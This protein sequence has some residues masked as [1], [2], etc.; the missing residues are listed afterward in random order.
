AEENELW[1][2]AIE[3]YSR[4]A[5]QYPGDSRFPWAL[6]SL[7]YSRR[8]YNLAWEQYRRVEA[9]GPQDTDILYRLSQTAGHLNWDWVSTEYLERIL[10]IDPGN[11]ESIGSLG[12]MYYK[13]HRPEEG[14]RLLLDAMDR[15]GADADYAMTLGTIYSDMFR[16]EEAKSWYLAAI[17]GGEE[18]G[19]REFTAVAHYNLSILE[20]RFYRFGLA[21]ERTNASLN[22]RNRASG[23]LARGELFLRRLDLPQTFAE[24][25]A[26]YEIDTSPLS[27][28]NLA[29]AYQI[30]GRLEEARL[31]AEDCLNSKDLSWMINYGIDPD[32]YKRDLHEILYITYEGLVKTQGRT[33]YASLGD[34]VRGFFRGWSYR[35][36]AASHR[37]LY[38]KYCLI[39]AGAYQ[40]ADPSAGER[41]DAL[42]R[43][44]NA[45][46]SYPR[47]ALTYLQKARQFEIPIIPQAES[48]YDAEEGILLKNTEQLAAAIPR[49][50]PLWER[51]VIAG[52]YAELAPQLAGKNRTAEA[53]DA[54]ERLYALNRGGLRQNGLTLPVELIINPGDGKDNPSRTERVLRRTLKKMGV[55]AD[56][57]GDN[58]SRFRLTITLSTGGGEQTALCDLYDSGR[59]ISLFR[60]SAALPSLSG[61]DISAFARELGDALFT[62]N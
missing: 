35:V 41:P 32:R 60:R 8:L 33:V 23:R 24:Y 39:V 44:Y 46:D 36:Q 16:Y 5:A 61:A 51:D 28:V 11:R 34:R 25:Q 21:F 15:F 20:S 45:F 31:Y 18:L 53:R 48:S 40:A 19:D 43:Y 14:E 52:A 10:E 58:P 22:S 37:R 26:A 7:Y 50:D 17:A 12:W 49:L 62:G 1:E 3:F 57:A 55:A 9:L 56:R 6:G 54:V 29:Q 47:R 38:Q 2:R 42:I 13:I 27:K 30:A 4:G 59:G